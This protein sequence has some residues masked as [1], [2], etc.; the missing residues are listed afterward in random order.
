MVKNSRICGVIV[1]KHEFDEKHQLKVGNMLSTFYSL[2]SRG[3]C[4]MIIL[5]TTFVFDA[6]LIHDV[7]FSLDNDVDIVKTEVFMEWSSAQTFPKT[8]CSPLLLWRRPARDMSSRW[9]NSFV[10]SLLCS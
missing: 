5:P 9:W 1:L 8:E 6:Q 3:L 10:T 7:N 4:L 2:Q